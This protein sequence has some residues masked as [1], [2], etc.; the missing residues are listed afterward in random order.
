MIDVLRGIR[1]IK[2]TR[3]VG[4]DRAVVSGVMKRTERRWLFLYEIDVLAIL[5]YLVRNS[6]TW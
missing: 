5:V 3:F 6:T 4:G 2:L 1:A